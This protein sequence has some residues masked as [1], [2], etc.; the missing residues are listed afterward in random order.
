[1]ALIGHQ[2]SI[3]LRFRGGKGVAT[4]LGFFLAI[5][6]L[7]SLVGLAVF[8]LVFCLWRIVSLASLAAALAMPLVL[9]LL[10]Y[11]TPTILT[12][13]IATLLIFAK[14]HGNIGRL[15]RWEEPGWGKGGSTPGAPASAPTPRQ[16]RNG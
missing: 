12:A 8:T 13:W 3:F 1:M 11:P 5:A 7:A 16:K 4:A 14:H 2:F 6:P 15:W 10:A 9:G